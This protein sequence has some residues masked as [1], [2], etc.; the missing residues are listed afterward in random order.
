MGPRLKTAVYQSVGAL[1]E[2]LPLRLS[3]SVARALAPRLLRRSPKWHHLRRNIAVISGGQGTGADLDR[4]TARG[5]ATYGAYWA[6][7][8][9]LPNLPQATMRRHFVIA[10]G[11]E[12]LEEAYAS[13][14]GVIVALPHT[15]SWEWG[16][17]IIADHGMPMT[18]VA[19]EVDPPELF[20]WFCQKRA[21]IGITVEG[22][23]AD[24]GTKLLTTLKEGG[25]VGLLCDR[26][27]QGGGAPVSFFG[28]AT[29]VPAGPATLALR[30]GAVLLTAACYMGPGDD[31]YAVITPP[32]EAERQGRMRDDVYRISQAVTTSLEGLIRRAP[33]QWH[34]LEDRFGAN[35]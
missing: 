16:G 1:L 2:H 24:A 19:E 30:T 21:Q 3:T 10:E 29:T 15:G 18:V 23:N 28:V 20:E 14:R 22:L 12:Y 11:L 34:V 7:G 17:A 31:H 25:V 9:K 4:Q 6:E 5:A 13:G 35:A 27:I 33:E 26:D 8:A 32:I